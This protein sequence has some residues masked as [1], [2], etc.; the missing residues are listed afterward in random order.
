MPLSPQAAFVTGA[1]K[2]IGRAIAEAL[3]ADGWRVALHYSKSER[4]AATVAFGIRQR[5]GICATVRGDLTNET[6]VGSLIQHATSVLEAPITC[7]VNNA[8]V[9]EHDTALSATRASWDK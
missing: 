8:S 1:S 7:L 2:R 6:H 3:A 5:G 4:E 9:F